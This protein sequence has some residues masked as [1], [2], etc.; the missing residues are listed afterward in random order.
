MAGTVVA[1]TIKSGT[2]GPAVFQNTSGTQIGTLCRAWVNFD[3]VTTATIRGSFNV[4]SV[5]RNG[6][7][8]YTVNFSNLL[9]DSN[10]AVVSQGQRPS[11]T[12]TAGVD[13][14]VSYNS[15]TAPSS[16]SFRVTTSNGAGSVQDFDIIS[17]GVFR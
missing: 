9:P 13:S 10:Y 12:A 3:G 17:L 11:G 7:G 8:D 16:S 1:D 5:T 14:I 2:S 4:S 15:T 6:T